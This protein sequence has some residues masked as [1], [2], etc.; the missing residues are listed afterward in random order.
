MVHNND[1]E[2]ELAFARL[3]QDSS[4]TNILVTDADSNVIHLLNN[5]VH[6]PIPQKKIQCKGELF[7]P[8]QINDLTLLAKES[9]QLLARNSAVSQPPAHPSNIRVSVV[10]N[11]LNI[12]LTPI[13]DT[14][15]TVSS[16]LPRQN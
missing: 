12:S 4:I 7:T 6:L 9:C 2:T 15:F 1:V 11:N 3:C 8:P 13:N 10:V 14:L 5:C 16:I